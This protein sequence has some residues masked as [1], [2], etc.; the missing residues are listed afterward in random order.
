[1][2]SYFIYENEK[3]FDKLF[4]TV[5]GTIVDVFKN[6]LNE[7]GFE[8]VSQKIK[9]INDTSYCVK[10]SDILIFTIRYEK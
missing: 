4:T 5:D 6:W 9:Q 3:K 7:N 1:M 2:E 8:E 10:V